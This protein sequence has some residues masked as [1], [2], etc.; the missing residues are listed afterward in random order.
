MNKITDI[1]NN[2]PTK[3]KEGFTGKEIQTLL[4]QYPDINMEKFHDA[5]RG[6]T[7]MMIDNEMIIYHCD[8][9][10]ALRCGLENRDP[11]AFEWD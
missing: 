6:I 5:L 10:L 2:F 9:E 1:V 11:T 3:N 4:K 7:C 8:V